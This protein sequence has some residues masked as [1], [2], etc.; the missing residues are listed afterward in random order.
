MFRIIDLKSGD[1]DDD[2]DGTLF[3]NDGMTLSA[4]RMAFA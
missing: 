1:K 2:S 4:C 3:Q